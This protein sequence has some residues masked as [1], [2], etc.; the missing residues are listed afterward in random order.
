MGFHRILANP[1]P[2]L[3]IGCRISPIASGGYWN[4]SLSRGW[5]GWGAADA[6]SEDH[7]GAVADIVRHGVEDARVHY[8]HVSGIARQ[9]NH[10]ERHVLDDRSLL[11]V[12]ADAIGAVARPKVAK[13]WV[14]ASQY[15]AG[16]ERANLIGG[17]ASELADQAMG[18]GD[19][20]GGSSSWRQ[21]LENRED[22]YFI[23]P[24]ADAARADIEMPHLVGD[25]PLAFRRWER[26]Q[27]AA[28]SRRPLPAS[29]REQVI[30]RTAHGLTR[31]PGECSGA[32]GRL[33]A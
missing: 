1:R 22:D 16:V 19:R 4:R 15:P 9:L 20:H 2:S 14:R 23:D 21:I 25:V 13:P 8:H 26:N 18:P 11:H 33:E 7:S 17:F 28:P 24:R 29:R 5:G 30:E 3:K 10:P 12:S 32:L 27:R 6:L 31:H